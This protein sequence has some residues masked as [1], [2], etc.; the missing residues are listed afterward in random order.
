[1][2]SVA[3]PAGAL[4]SSRLQS[5]SSGQ[6]MHGNAVCDPGKCSGSC[7]SYG[8]TS[9]EMRGLPT[10]GLLAVLMLSEYPVVSSASCNAQGY[11]VRR[12]HVVRS[13][14]ANCP[15]PAQENTVPSCMSCSMTSSGIGLKCTVALSVVKYCPP[16]L[17]CWTR[18][19]PS[20]DG[21]ASE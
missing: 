5:T 11:D 4:S 16:L 20:V 21:G 17:M 12:W 9:K 18:T 13:R 10:A 19:E 14:K 7:K 3:R 15:A 8:L 6:Q 2:R 1:M